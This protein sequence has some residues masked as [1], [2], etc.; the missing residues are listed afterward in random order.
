MADS[1]KVRHATVQLRAVNAPAGWDAWLL[2]VSAFPMPEDELEPVKRFCESVSVA[3]MNQ[4]SLNL[5]TLIQMEKLHLGDGADRLA[6]NGREWIPAIGLGVWPDRDPPTLWTREEFEALDVNE[7]PRTL[8]YQVFRVTTEQPARHAAR[9]RM[10]GLG[11]VLE[12]FT[13]DDSE[14]FLERA[15]EFLLPPIKEKS[16]NCFPFY[17]SLLEAKSFSNASPEQLNDWFCGADAYLRESPEDEGILIAARDSLD[18]LFGSL[19]GTR[20]SEPEPAWTF[21]IPL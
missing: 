8:M 17:A 14:K 11:T 16:F 20:E 15:R 5:E 13:R 1:P 7:M 3:L 21:S 6:D 9:D 4:R 2:P 19:K 18:E 10:I 12:I